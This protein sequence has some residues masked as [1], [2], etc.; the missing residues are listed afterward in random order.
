MTGFRAFILTVFFV[1][2]LNGWAVFA[3]EKATP[4]QV[5]FTKFRATVLEAVTAV[6]LQTHVPIGIIFGH[7]KTAFCNAQ[8]D[9]DLREVNVEGALL[10][11]A[12]RAH[13]F[14]TQENGEFFLIAADITPRQHAVLDHRFAEFKPPQNAVPAMISA[15]LAGWLWVDLDHGDGYGGSTLYSVGEPRISLPAS[16]RNVTTEEIANR[17]VT[18]GAGGLWIAKINPEKATGPQDELI[19][20]YSYGNP[21]LFKTEITCEQR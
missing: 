2:Q 7:D 8:S 20:F 19:S 1:T 15:Q 12:Q 5:T 21:E 18:T 3:Q 10:L 11:A 13:Y 4:P 17:V 6:G 9:F 16:M 14:L